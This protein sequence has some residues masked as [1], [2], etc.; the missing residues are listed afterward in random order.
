[1]W[2]MANQGP[3]AWAS[4]ATFAVSAIG[5]VTNPMPPAA[6]PTR[7][8]DFMASSTIGCMSHRYLAGD[9]YTIADMICY[10][11]TV[12][13]KVQGQDIEEFTYFKRWFEEVGQRPAVQRGN[14]CWQRLIDRRHQTAS[15]RTGADQEAALQSASHSR[16]VASTR[17]WPLPARRG[18]W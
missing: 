18:R 4:A 12:N 2:Q 3:Q 14:G 16:A 15:R 5:K 11:W 10:P 9:A 6:S 7:Q 17:R 1:M 13:W 8:I